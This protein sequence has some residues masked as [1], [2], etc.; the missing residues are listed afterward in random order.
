MLPS[1]NWSYP[2]DLFPSF[3]LCHYYCPSDLQFPQEICCSLLSLSSPSSLLSP[4]PLLY[5]ILFPQGIRFSKRQRREIIPAQGNA[6]VNADKRPRAEGPIHQCHHPESPRHVH[7]ITLP[8]NRN[9]S[10]E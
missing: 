4:L 10:P 8:G 9:P 3:F 6:L 1:T 2:Y 7:A 5:C